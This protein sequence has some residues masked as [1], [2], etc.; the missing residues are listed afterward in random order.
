MHQADDERT[1]IGCR[2]RFV[3]NLAGYGEC[4]QA[5]TNQHH[6]DCCIEHARNPRRDRNTGQHQRSRRQG[7]YDRV[8]QTPHRAGPRSSRHRAPT[9]YERA[10]SSNVIRFEGVLQTKSQTKHARCQNRHRRGP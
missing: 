3:L 7:E 9:R 1:S 6:G 10:H 2:R 8:P 5:E 4:M